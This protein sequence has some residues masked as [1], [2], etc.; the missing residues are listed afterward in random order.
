MTVVAPPG[1][2]PATAKPEGAAVIV[3]LATVPLVPATVAE[4]PVAVEV[5]VAARPV[6][7]PVPV[8]ATVSFAALAESAAPDNGMAVG[9]AES[10]E[11][12]ADSKSCRRLTGSGWIRTKMTARRGRIHTIRWERNS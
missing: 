10:L 12:D 3:G 8:A 1:M 9:L 11:T 7:R 6:D 4:V 2:R 5:I